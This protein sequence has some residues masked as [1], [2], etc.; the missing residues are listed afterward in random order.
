MITITLKEAYAKATKGPLEVGRGL[1]IQQ[2]GRHG[3]GRILADTTHDP[4]EGEAGET[5]KYDAA[6]LAH[7]FNHFQ[8]V[9]EA[10][11]LAA[12]QAAVLAAHIPYESTEYRKDEAGFRALISKASKVKIP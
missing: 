6:L 3:N 10:L 9:V 11:E 4:R 8:E 1:R 2:G 5:R 7:C 12:N